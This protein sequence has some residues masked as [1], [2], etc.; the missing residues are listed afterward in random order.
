MLNSVCYHKVLFFFIFIYSCSFYSAH[1]QTDAAVVQCFVWRSLSSTSRGRCGRRRSPEISQRQCEGWEGKGRRKH[2]CSPG[3][4]V[5]L[6][7]GH[8]QSCQQRGSEIYRQH[9]GKNESSVSDRRVPDR[10]GCGEALQP[11]SSSLMSVS[12]SQ[13]SRGLLWPLTG[14]TSLH[15]LKESH[16]N[17]S[18]TVHNKQRPLGLIILTEK[19]TGKNTSA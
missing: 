18:A 10:P 16:N 12:V 6:L 3:W 1:S 2:G 9:Q 19:P 15:N 8:R 5:F 14:E 17:L 7:R 13:Q 4:H 11:R